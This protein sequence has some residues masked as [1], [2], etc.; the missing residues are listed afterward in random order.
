MSPTVSGRISHSAALHDTGLYFLLILN[1]GV[2]R[3]LR[4]GGQRGSG[5][6]SHV[7]GQSPAGGALRATRSRYISLWA[8]GVLVCIRSTLD[9]LKMQVLP[10]QKQQSN[11]GYISCSHEPP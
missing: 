7:H 4:Y 10:Y 1:S 6:S 9:F 8:R 2:A 11:L 3:V 5:E